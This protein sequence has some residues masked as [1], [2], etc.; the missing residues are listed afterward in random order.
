MDNKVQIKIS[1]ILRMLKEGYTRKDLAEH[2]DI[3][4]TAMKKIFQHPELKGKRTMPKVEDPYVLIDDVNTPQEEP[5]I[6]DDVVL[7]GE[8]T[9]EEVQ[10]EEEDAEA[11]AEYHAAVVMQD[12]EEE[13]DPWGNI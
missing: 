9:P 1:D 2:Y 5:A 13:I 4:Q 11:E 7:E 8:E 12:T 6:A 10:K 3:T